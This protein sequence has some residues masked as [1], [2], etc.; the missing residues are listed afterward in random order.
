MAK[1]E[2]GTTAYY[3]LPV[4][5]RQQE[6][7]EVRR[8]SGGNT[9]PIAMY[10]SA[11]EQTYIQTQS[12]KHLQG[13]Q[14]EVK[15]KF[16]SQAAYLA[17]P[18]IANILHWA[19]N[20]GFTAQETSNALTNSTWWK[21]HTPAQRQWFQLN[22][23]DSTAAFQSVQQ[24]YD[25]ITHQAQGLG[26]H[27]DAKTKMELSTQ[28]LAMGWD[29]Q[30]LLDQILKQSRGVNLN[31]GSMGVTRQQLAGTADDY[32]IGVSN[33]SLDTWT[34]RVAAGTES[35]DSFKAAMQRHAMGRYTDPG[36]RDTLTHGGT[37]RDFADS[38]VQQAAQTLGVNA[39]D[40]D[41]SQGKWRRPIDYTDPKTGHRRAM[42]MDEWERTI[43]M[44]P[45]YGYDHSKN[46]VAEAAQL[47]GQIRQKFGVS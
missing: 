13:W 42:T 1:P 8:H 30:Q 44:D 32:L 4:A 46:G 28:T 39:K 5:Q 47:A 11:P 19:T 9:V 25:A 2:P 23:T 34:R 38:Y 43:K 27:L 20:A 26:I 18:E 7:D 22:T 21:S 14:E 29:S 45:S 3:Q 24:Q 6:Y 31:A 36:I 33:E 40:I 35:V 15:K 10:F 41:L 37:V 12:N 16:P 17:V